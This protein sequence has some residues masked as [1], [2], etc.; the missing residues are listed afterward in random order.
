MTGATCF[1]GIGAPEVSTPWVTWKWCAEI[2]PFPSSVMAERHPGIPNLGD[3]TANDFTERAKQYGPIDIL[4]GGAPCQDFSVAGLRAGMD[5]ARGNLSLRFLELIGELRPTWV[6]FENVPGMLS[7]TSHAAPDPCPPPDDL[8]PGCEWTTEDDYESEEG[9]DFGYFLAAFSE[10]GYDL[11]WTVLDAQYFHLA[12]RRERVF[13]VGHLRGVEQSGNAGEVRNGGGFARLPAAVLF[14]L[15]SLC[16]NSPPSRAARKEVADASGISASKCSEIA[17]PLNTS[18][19]KRSPGSQAQEWDSER[20]GRFV[21]TSG[22]VPERGGQN[23]IDCESETFIVATLDASYGR[24]QGCSGQDANHGHSHLVVQPSREIFQCQHCQAKYEPSEYRCPNCRRLEAFY[25]RPDVAHSLRGDGFDASED[26]TGRGTPLVAVPCIGVDEEQN[27][28]SELMGCL[29]RRQKGG[30]FEGFVAMPI[31]EAGART[32]KSTDDL[33]AGSGIGEPGDPM[34]TLQSGKQHAVAFTCKDHGA[35]AGDI[36]PT[37]RSMGHA[38]SHANGGGQVAVVAAPM[39]V[40]RL[41]PRE[42]ERLQGFE[43]DYTLI[44]FRGK[45]AADGPRYRSL[46]NS[47]ACPVIAWITNKIRIAMEVER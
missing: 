22:D 37:L 39:A 3:V 28:Q 10:L 33:R 43:D 45:P 8:Q 20:G 40:R 29:K 31:L 46:G 2:E 42:A 19:G 15:E 7:S 24:L 35:D 14:D 44:E 9:S 25:V 16:G 34:F 5:G 27:A 4:V 1:S 38:G 6:L 12:Q 21:A 36:A 11:A 26:G 47:M 32:G 17:P 41:T 23:R 30:G 18:W 13:V